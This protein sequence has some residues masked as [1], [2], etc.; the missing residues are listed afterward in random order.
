VPERQIKMAGH[1]SRLLT[2]LQVVS[3]P[4][5][6]LDGHRSEAAGAE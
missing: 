4:R 3:R 2:A 6:F 5:F 1:G